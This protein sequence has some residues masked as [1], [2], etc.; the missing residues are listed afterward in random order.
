MDGSLSKN[1]VFA[2]AYPINVLRIRVVK[3][4]SRTIKPYAN[5]QIWG[6]YLLEVQLVSS[7]LML[8][9]L[10]SFIWTNDIVEGLGFVP[11]FYTFKV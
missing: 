6:Q 10:P 5:V 3:G 11:I 2:V 9:C 1:V 7:D 8:L 4:R